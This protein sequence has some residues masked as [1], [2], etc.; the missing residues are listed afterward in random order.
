MGS[1]AC[2]TCPV[3][4]LCDQVSATRCE[5]QNSPESFYCLQTGANRKV[6]CPAGKYTY[7]DRASQLSDCEVCPKGNY[8]PT[9]PASALEKIVAC[10]EG[11]YCLEGIS[12][13]SS[14]PCPAGFY[15]PVGTYIPLPCS[16]GMYCNGLQNAKPTGLCKVG[17]YC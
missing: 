4:Y 14:T 17:Y 7:K 5:P 11:Y 10:P 16:V 2:L 12:D 3:G 1:T 15:C 6:S 9:T 8:C 13:Y